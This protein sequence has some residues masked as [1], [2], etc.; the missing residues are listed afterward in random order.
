[1]ST[2]FGASGASAYLGLPTLLIAVAFVVRGWRS[3]GARFLLAALLVPSLIA[4]GTTLRVDGHSVMRLPWSAATHLPVI[5]NALPFRFT[6]YVS[7][8]AAV[9][10][11][12]WTASTRGR[13]FTR[14]YVLPVLAVV[15]LVPAVWRTDY[16]SFHATDPQRLAFFT[17]GLYKTCIPQNETV[18]IFPFGPGVS[19]LAQAETSFW[20]R[21]AEDGLQAPNQ[22]LNSFDAERIVY[23]LNYMADR[24][25]PTMDRLLAFVAT[26]HVGRVVSAVGDGYPT[27]AQMRSFGSTQR[28]GGVIVSPAC[29]QPPLTTRNLERYVKADPYEVIGSAPNVGWCQGLT[30]TELPQGLNPVALLAGAKRAIFVVGQGVTCAPPPPGYTRHGFATPDLG[31]PANTYA[32]YSKSS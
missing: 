24:G 5:N 32:F 6:A 2:H 3:P 16:P 21:L 19:Q 20:F 13:I 28:I 23:E 7:L 22:A 30:F 26:H 25:R 8:A 10:V 11:A 27:A 17:D 12:A 4:L 18:V 14:P 31:V 29:G 1:L 9:I 15:A